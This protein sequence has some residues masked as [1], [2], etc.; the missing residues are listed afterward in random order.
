MWSKEA[1]WEPVTGMNEKGDG[2][3]AGKRLTEAK[4][5]QGP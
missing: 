4:E 3:G 5:A 2:E 1:P